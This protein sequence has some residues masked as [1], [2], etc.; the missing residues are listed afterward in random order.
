VDPELLVLVVGYGRGMKVLIE[1][2]KARDIPVVELQHGAGIVNPQHPGYHYPEAYPK[3]VFPD[4]VLTWGKFWSQNASLPIPS[5]RVIVVGYPYLDARI[6]RYDNIPQRD[7][8]LFISQGTVGEKLSQFA[9]SCAADAHITSDIVYKLHPGEADR[10]RDA[11]PWLLDS[12]VT[13]I[14]GQSPPLYELF[15]KSRAQ[16][17]VGSTA[18]YEG[19][20][21]GLETYVYDIDGASTLMPLVDAGAAEVINSVDALAARLGRGADTFDREYYFAADA[22]P[23]VQRTLEQLVA[24]GTIYKGG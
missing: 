9:A 13:V 3:Q 7:Q 5:E 19:L 6:E 8:L 1:M 15:A 18:V 4:Y 21:F 22:L 2:A 17:G 16:V 12:A 20:Y 23:R 11:Y 10:W 24:S 14:D